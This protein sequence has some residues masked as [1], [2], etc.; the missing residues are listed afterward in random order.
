[1]SIAN[2]QETELETLRKRVAKLEAILSIN[3][4]SQADDSR[5]EIQKQ[6]RAIAEYTYDWEN[7]VGTDGKPIWIN[8]AVERLTGYT[9]QECLAMT[10]F[11]KPLIY[12]EDWDKITFYYS[13]AMK[14]SSGN[15]LEFR[16]RRKDSTLEWVTASWQPIYDSTGKNIGHRSSIRDIGKRKHIQDTL[17]Q[18]EKRY[19][20]L[21]N[22][23]HSGVAVYEA[24]D[25]GQ[26]FI[27]ADMNHA[28]EQSEQINKDDMVGKSV[29]QIFPG[30]KSFGLFDVFQRVWRTGQPEHHPVSF[31]QDTRIEGWRENYVYKLPS[32]EIVAVYED[33]TE[34]K[35]AEE[36]A[37]LDELRLEGLLRISHYKANTIHELLQ[38]ALEEAIAL[39]A[40]E[41]GYLYF[42]D[43]EKKQFTLNSW[44]SHVMEECSIENPP[45]IYE[46]D[47][48][49]MWGDAVRK[50]EPIILN[51]FHA[52]N[53]SK[54]GYPDGHA[55][56]HRF[57]TI[58]IFSDNQIVAVVGVANRTT[59]YDSSDVRQLTLMMDTVWKYVAR[60]QAKQAL[61]ESEEKYRRIID[62]AN[63][64]IW[65][66]DSDFNTVFANTRMADMLGC[67]TE[68]LAGKEFEPFL[69]KE[70]LADH[71]LRR[72][73]RRQGIAEHYERRFRRAD[74]SVV[75]TL[76]SATP[77][78]D[79]EHKFIGSFGMFTD[80]TDRKH[81]E[82]ALQESETKYRRIIDTANEGIWALD[83]DF[84]TAFANQQMADILGCQIDEM[85]GHGFEPFLFEEDWQDHSVRME[86]RRQGQAEHYERRFR[87]K[88]GQVVYTIVSA[89]PLFDD[90][91][92]F[93]GS[94]G[95]FTDITDRKN[96]EREIQNRTEDLIILNA[97]ATTLNQP[98][99]L[100]NMLNTVLAQILDVLR[101]EAGAIYLFDPDTDK[102]T[103]STAQGIP[104]TSFHSDKLLDMTA[105]IFKKISKHRQPIILDDP[106]E[107]LDNDNPTSAYPHV[108]VPLENRERVI[109][110]LVFGKCR[111][112]MTSPQGIQFLTA[113]GHQIG[114]AVA[115]VQLSKNAVEVQL[116][117]ELDQLRSELVANVSHELRTPLGLIKLF[118]TSLLDKEVQFEESVRREFL[119][120]IERETNRLESV[121]DNLL[122]LSRIQSGRLR[123]EKHLVDLK[124]MIREVAQSMWMHNPDFY[125]S[126]DIK[127]PSLVVPVDA[128]RIEQ[129]LRNLISNAIKYSPQGRTIAIWG[130]D[131]E[132][133][134]LVQVRDEGIGIAPAD[135]PKVFERF[136]R[137]DNDVTRHVGGAGLGLA[138]CQGIV[139]LHGG[140]IWAEST[141]G[142]GSTFSFTLPID[143]DEQ[144]RDESQGILV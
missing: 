104:A 96:A 21:F 9:V 102:Q 119:E 51:D 123:L 83:S 118:C 60:Q 28:G 39:T 25:D 17:L 12:E 97:I 141:L 120:S 47:R 18:S 129:V 20:E 24:R 7:W 70:D 116:L 13:E 143:A 11:P 77:L 81:V 4:A 75:H 2:Q 46:L 74:A 40:S 108:V 139:Q 16:I 82:Q 91:H 19:R 87:R 72:E 67:S 37:K 59:D 5:I 132:H 92:K 88:D 35:R 111:E 121:V 29:Q 69:L 1:M 61:V 62:T 49:G 117:R 80:I 93:S 55:T 44:S 127:A 15:D 128:K 136:Y 31:Y 142:R 6:F 133:Y 71:A 144:V 103:L 89:M 86:R 138:I 26:D 10:D 113:L 115:N 65:V 73:R 135:L 63:E 32:G 131:N 14:G 3:T 8:S 124:Q 100:E 56:L 36:T 23:T 34:R 98:S 76:V 126:V 50:R 64:G 125:I 54:K 94:F 42:Y 95:M 27:L 84:N 53:P 22:R 105:D 90:Q 140:R 122:D 134:V 110:I 68:E 43:E 33:V 30:I 137:I 99:G 57:M 109:G 45:R 114:V 41:I 79:A 66:L 78:F 107:F 85:L 101:L 58:P 52:P 112:R 48:T 38:Y 106:Q 130:E